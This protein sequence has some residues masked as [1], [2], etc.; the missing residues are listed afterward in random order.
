[1]DKEGWAQNWN[2]KLKN[3]QYYGMLNVVYNSQTSKLLEG[4][5]HLPKVWGELNGAPSKAL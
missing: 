2:K 5:T 3:S 4:G 1:M